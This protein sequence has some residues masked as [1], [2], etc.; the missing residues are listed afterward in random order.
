MTQPWMLLFETQ[1]GPFSCWDSRQ[2]QYYV[3]PVQ[4]FNTL[5][6]FVVEL[7]LESAFSDMLY[8]RGT[9][10]FLWKIVRQCYFKFMFRRWT[11][12]KRQ[13][14][15]GNHRMA[16]LGVSLF[17]QQLYSVE[18]L[19]ALHATKWRMH[20]CFRTFCQHVEFGSVATFSYHIYDIEPPV[21][22]LHR[23][24]SGEDCK[25]VPG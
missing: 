17:M 10:V 15:T 8:F 5:Q 25:P 24:P 9:L 21:S 4:Y 19:V 20:L 6:G 14:I 11:A 16:L 13:S 22:V 18:V 1:E 2:V 7:K 12:A 23:S 3:T